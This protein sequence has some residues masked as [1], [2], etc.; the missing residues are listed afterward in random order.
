MV[1]RYSSFRYSFCCG[2]TA[3]MMRRREALSVLAEGL[4]LLRVQLHRSGTTCWRS[5]MGEVGAL[6]FLF[7]MTRIKE[8]KRIQLALDPGLCF[9][10]AGM[11]CFLVVV[12]QKPKT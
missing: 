3:M 11:T 10:G 2:I 1:L 9:Q 12:P 7:V 5:P 8:T 6:C 4:K